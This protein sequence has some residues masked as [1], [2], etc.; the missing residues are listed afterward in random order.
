MFITS[1]CKRIKDNKLALNIDYI[2]SEYTEEEINY[3][4]EYMM[5]IAVQLID[6]SDKKIKEI[7][8]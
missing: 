5:Y 8:K 1:Y 7:I 6:N 4:Q 3:M 2:T